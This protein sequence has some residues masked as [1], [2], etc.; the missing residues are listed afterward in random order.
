A[1]EGLVDRRNQV[2]RK[3]SGRRHRRLRN[4]LQ[5]PL[6]RIRTAPQP[7]RDRRRL[8]RALAGDHG[9]AQGGAF[10]RDVGPYPAYRSSDRDWLG[11]IP[12]HWPLTPLKHLCSFSGGGTPSKENSKYWIGGDIPWVSPK[13]MKAARISDSFDH[14]TAQAVAESSTAFIQP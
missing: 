6:L 14:V 1:C 2:R 4:P 5:S 11:N 10:V 13:D 7:R 12:V 9:D 8:R 3:R